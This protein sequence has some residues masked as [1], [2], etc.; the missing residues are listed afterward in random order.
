ML[1]WIMKNKDSILNSFK[2]IVVIVVSMILRFILE[3]KKDE[4]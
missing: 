2:I 4:H 1:N 3:K